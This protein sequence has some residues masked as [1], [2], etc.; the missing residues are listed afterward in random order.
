MSHDWSHR[1]YATVSYPPAAGVWPVVIDSDD[2]CRKS[3]DGSLV[4][5]RW[6]GALPSPLSGSTVYDHAGILSIL[7][8]PDWTTPIDP[9]PED[10]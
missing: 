6:E 2:T 4:L 3:L 9:P 8:G 5:A 7:A 1:N 10:P